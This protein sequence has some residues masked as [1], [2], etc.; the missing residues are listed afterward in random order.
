MK[1]LLPAV[2]FVLSLLGGHA[3]AE[4]LTFTTYYHNDHLGN[5]VAATDERGDLLWRAHF[6]PYGERHENPADN[7]F[8]TVGYTGH[9]H[10]KTSGLVYMGARYYDP[11][12]GRF[13]AVDPVGFQDQN[14]Q[15][16]GR[17][18]YA[19]N[20]PHKYTDPDGRSPLLLFWAG[21]AAFGGAM[22]HSDYAN[23]PA[24]GE[25]PATMSTFD[26]LGALPSLQGAKGAKFLGMAD[27]AKVA[28]KLARYDGP[29]PTYHINPAHVP[30]Q[31]GF[32]PTKTPLPKDAETVF[33]N[34]VP[35]DS[36]NPTAWFG[37]NPDGQIYRYSLGND[38][39]A[40]FS[41]TDGIGDGVRNL[42]KYAK[43]R[44]SEL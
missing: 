40:H 18:L 28:K 8:G 1:R 32:N 37:K 4:T 21:A 35:N 25:E 43:D 41:G 17:Y 16:F 7:A 20:N 29:K 27:E 14:P 3:L 44:L 30:G 24:Q 12:I 31:R 22:A 11:V 39:T 6:T 19:N 15:S 33:S 10:D 5:P 13:M 9:A 42:T 38:G 34:A 23:A 2:A 26:H 36:K